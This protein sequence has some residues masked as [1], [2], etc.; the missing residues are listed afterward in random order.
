MSQV[1][2]DLLLLAGS[3]ESILL[4]LGLESSVSELGAGIDELE[5][6]LLQGR[7]LGVLQQAFSESQDSLLWSNDA[8]LDHKEILTDNTVM[9]ETTHGGNWL[10][11]EIVLSGG[12]LW[13]TSRANSVH[14]LVEFSTMMV[15]VLTSSR[16]TETDSGRMPSSDTG[17]LSETSVGLSGKSASSPTSG[18]TFVT[19]T[20]G[21]SDDVNVLVQGENSSNWDFLLKVLLG[22]LN[23]VLGV[24]SIDLNF[25]DV[26]LLLSEV[27]LLDLGVGNDTNNLAVLDNSFQLL[28][29]WLLGIV[30]LLVVLGEG[31]LLA[32]VPVLVHSSDECLTQVL[33]KHSCQGSESSGGLDVSNNTDN[34][35]WWAFQDGDGLNNLLL[36]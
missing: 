26:G 23:F 4:L 9:G 20:L 32:V 12:V 27:E 15:S 29:N 19:M 28:L 10:L 30:V 7:S 17:N 24:S 16:N 34:N 21:H 22:K 36:V 1:E 11:S 25:H 31:F 33:G 6:D 8:T 18:D 13:V 5:I 35:H 3:Q 2:V 14:L